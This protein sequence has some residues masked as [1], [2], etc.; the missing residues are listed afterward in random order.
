MIYIHISTHKS[1]QILFNNRWHIKVTCKQTTSVKIL[2]F[3]AFSF[4]DVSSAIFVK[5]EK[6]PE[7]IEWPKI[8]SETGVSYTDPRKRRFWNAVPGCFLLRKNFWNGVSSQKY[9]RLFLLLSLGLH[10]SSSCP[11][12]S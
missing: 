2:S 10:R 3:P 12:W 7:C 9:P 6:V 4:L 8:W 5:K 11:G 1:Y